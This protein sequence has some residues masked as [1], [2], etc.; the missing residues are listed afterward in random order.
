[1]DR[2]LWEQLK[3]ILEIALTLDPGDRDTYLREACSGSQTLYEEARK[4]LA[5]E[6]PLTLEWS[7]AIRVLEQESVCQEGQILGHYRLIKEIG[8]GGMGAVFL[9][10]RIDGEYEQKVAIKILQVERFSE[11]LIQ[12]LRNERQILANLKHPNIVNI[13]DGGTSDQ[14]IPFIVMEY[15][16]GINMIGYIE[17]HNLDLNQKLRLFQKLCEVISFAHEK[18]IIHRDIK[19]SNILINQAGEI[20]L[21]DFGIAKIIN[22]QGQ[23]FQ[24]TQ[25]LFITPD[26][27]SPE[28]IKGEALSISSEV[29]SLGILFYQILTGINPFKSKESSL[30]SMMEM[31]CEY[32]PLPPSKTTENIKLK[33]DL[34]NICLKALRKDPK[35]RFLSVDHFSQ[36]IEN[37]LQ[38]LPVKATKDQWS[39]RAKKFMVRNRAYVVSAIVIFL[40]TLAGLFISL[41][42]AGVAKAMFNDL[43]GL[44]GSMLFEFYDGVAS[45][46]GA[47]TV[48][49]LVV[50]KTITYLKKMETKN[51]GNPDL[52]NEISEG[53]QRLGNIQGNSYVA[54]MGKPDDA[55]KSFRKAVDI[56]EK[57]VSTYPANQNYL[58]SLSGAYL[59]IGDVLYTLNRLDSTLM[60]YQKSNQLLIALSYNYSDSLKYGLSL[61]ESY[62]R[63]GD[64][65]GMYG[66]S[67]LGNTSIAISSY[68]KSVDILERLL[69]RHPENT[70]I[71]HSLGSCLSLLAS[72][73]SVTG[74]YL[75]AIEAGYKSITSFEILL[76]MYPQNYMT[77]AN[78]LQAKNS[79]REALTE[80][81]RLEEALTLLKEVEFR[82][83]ESLRLDSMNQLTQENLAINYNAI[84][85]LLT[86]K[87]ELNSAIK[88]HQHAHALLKESRNNLGMGR[89]S[90]L[91]LEFM[92]NAYFENKQYFEAMNKFDEARVVYKETDPTL[93]QVVQVKINI[94]RLYLKNNHDSLL[95]QHR[96]SLLAL[97]KKSKDDTLN[98]KN[99]V[100]LIELYDKTARALAL[101]RTNLSKKS[102]INDPCYYYR[103]SIEL[104]DHLLSKNALS[105]L[106]MQKRDE[107]IKS[108]ANCSP[109]FQYHLGPG[110]D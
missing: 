66:Y 39:Y 44:T 47:T 45:L 5:A 89:N 76:K 88:A 54:N 79:M 17:E 55:L 101:F 67:N 87:G 60:M 95:L 31:I 51:S 22:P 38:H 100:I 40:I 105:P 110:Y 34:D 1:M 78:I 80:T 20:K 93:I 104:A 21:L 68:H 13:L 99:V 49:E 91:T 108:L 9:A 26:Y 36:D 42:H 98:I 48:K 74:N 86:E 23:S 53:Y 25:Q 73:N 83:T 37:Y 81:M 56:S 3:P 10:E 50:S 102:E 64:V 92:G 12:K 72:L 33:G 85:R 77:M 27:A 84:G 61:S 30:S 11:S 97:E 106:R 62:T 57:L 15:V 32:N 59:G 109:Q 63:I 6:D 19:P 41:Y 69:D 82:L 46:E 65:S 28:H 24:E 8:R 29:Y 2:S 70:D 35:E 16:D 7:Q 96:E 75:G 103:R 94:C 90:G 52:M 4:L 58:F 18:L 43:R 14:G 107:L 71:I